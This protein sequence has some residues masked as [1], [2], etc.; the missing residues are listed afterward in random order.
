MFSQPS[1]TL[2][3]RESV[4]TKFPRWQ[5]DEFVLKPFLQLYLVNSMMTSGTDEFNTNSSQNFKPSVCHPFPIGDGR[6]QYWHTC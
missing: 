3:K 5:E 4:R 6:F 1:S 2:H